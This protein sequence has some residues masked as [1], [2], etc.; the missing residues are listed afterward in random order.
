MMVNRI[1]RVR[2]FT[3]D[4]F[5]K[6]NVGNN[7]YKTKNFRVFTKALSFAKM[8]CEPAGV[9]GIDEINIHLVG[10]KE[11]EEIGTQWSV[12]PE[13]HVIV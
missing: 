2:Y 10:K 13:C 3:D 12:T 6:N 11:T 8:H 1:F 4:N 7:P 9:S 5:D